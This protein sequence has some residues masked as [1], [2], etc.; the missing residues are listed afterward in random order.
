MAAAGRIDA[1]RLACLL[2]HPY[3]AAAAPK[4]LDR[5]QFSPQPVEG[6]AAADGAA[7]LTAFT[8]HSVARALPLLPAAPL[9][10]LVTGG[11]RHNP[12]L[13]AMLSDALAAPVEPVETVGW[14]GDA[15][16]AQA[17][18]HLAVRSLYGL[19]LS[20]PGTTGVP[21]PMTGGVHHRAR[22]AA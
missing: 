4:S 2:D 16:E 15:L 21:R 11:G 9:R 10:W 18:A 12:V 20:L 17:F 5:N 7:T 13:M 6:L 22:S 8:A 1:A 19:A 14:D 3:F